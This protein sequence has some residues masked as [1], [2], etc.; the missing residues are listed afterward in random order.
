MDLSH[1]PQLLLDPLE[2][3]IVR[4]IR[5]QQQARND[6]VENLGSSRSSVTQS[7]NTLIKRGILTDVEVGEST[8]GRR[9]RLLDVNDTFG[10][11][12]GIHMGA[13]GAGVCVANFRGQII[14]WCRVS[15]WIN[16]APVKVMDN[17]FDAVFGLLDQHRIPHERLYGIGIGVP[18]P[19]DKYSGTIVSPATMLGWEKYSIADYCSEHFLHAIV[20]IDNDVN[21][22]A[23]GE[24][25]AGMGKNHDNFFFVKIGTGIGCGIVS[26]GQIYRGATGCSGHI[27]HVSVDRNGPVCSCGNVGCLEKFAAG[28]AIAEQALSAAREGRSPILAEIMDHRGGTLLPEDVGNA[29]GRGDKIAN[30]IIIE[31]GRVIGEV[32]ATLVSFFNPSLVIVGGGVSNIGPQFLISLHRTILEYSLPLSTRDCIIR[33]SEMGY[34]AGMEGAVGLALDHIFVSS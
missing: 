6:L 25:L 33:R 17:V 29:A 15:F 31:S 34:R 32:L 20:K 3:S 22:M 23:M 30:D 4:S 21:L 10:Y 14:D 26:N 2:Y 13:T 7:V 19:V 18:A 27:G 11:I 1:P 28:P 16:D 12:V 24:L 9:P 5:Q 8:G